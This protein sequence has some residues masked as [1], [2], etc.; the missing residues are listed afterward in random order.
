MLPQLLALRLVSGCRFGVAVAVLK[1]PAESTEQAGGKVSL[2]EEISMVAAILSLEHTEY[3]SRHATTTVTNMYSNSIPTCDTQVTEFKSG[4]RLP[5]ISC[6]I[7]FRFGN[8]SR[9]CA[10]GAATPEEVI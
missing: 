2:D 6:D 3:S 4:S 5:F 1:T 8:F 7:L 10:W 9:E